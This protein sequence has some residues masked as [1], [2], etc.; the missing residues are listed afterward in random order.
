MVTFTPM[1]AVTKVRNQPAITKPRLGRACC[2]SD[3]SLR[4]PDIFGTVKHTTINKQQ[5]LLTATV[6]NTFPTYVN[7]TCGV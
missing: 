4:V 2:I 7:V 6:Y 5:Y 1:C 3:L